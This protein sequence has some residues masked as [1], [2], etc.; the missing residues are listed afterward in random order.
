MSRYNINNIFIEKA[1]KV[2]NAANIGIEYTTAM[3]KY[4]LHR[5][6]QPI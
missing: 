4:P 2:T 6:V 1:L 5:I 3:F